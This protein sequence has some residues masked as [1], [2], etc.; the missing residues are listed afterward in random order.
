MLAQAGI[1]VTD[2]GK[3]RA[4]AKL[5]AAERRMTPEAW[6]RL[7]ERFGRAA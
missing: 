2:E 1:A 7:A 4:R 5:R 3:A 6:A